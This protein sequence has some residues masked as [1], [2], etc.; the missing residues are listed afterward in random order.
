MLLPTVM[1]VTGKRLGSLLY[2]LAAKAEG[3][4]DPGVP[5]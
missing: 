1:H 3:L 4:H 2:L 5:L